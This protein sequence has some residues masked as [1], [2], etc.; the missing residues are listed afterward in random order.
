MVKIIDDIMILRLCKNYENFSKDEQDMEH[1]NGMHP[2]K[3]YF[4]KKYIFLEV[5]NLKGG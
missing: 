5:E 2:S 4:F 1:L 3:Y